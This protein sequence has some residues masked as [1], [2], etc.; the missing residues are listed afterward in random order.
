MDLC[1]LILKVK[2]LGFVDLGGVCWLSTIILVYDISV[3]N[4]NNE[5]QLMQ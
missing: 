4:I 5:F 3:V 1:E 2:I